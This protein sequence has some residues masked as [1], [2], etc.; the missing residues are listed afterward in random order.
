VEEMGE[1]PVVETG[2]QD[3][4]S[5]PSKVQLVSHYLP[6]ARQAAHDFATRLPGFVDRNALLAAAEDG[7]LDAAQK[8]DT[9]RGDFW[10]YASRRIYGC[11]KD[12]LRREDFMNQGQRRRSRDIATAD[13]ELRASG[14]HDPSDAQIAE[15]LKLPEQAVAESRRLSHASPLSLDADFSLGNGDN[16]HLH[17]ILQMDD[18]PVDEQYDAAEWFHLL[19][20]MISGGFLSHNELFVLYHCYFEGLILKSIGSMM[21]LTE[22][23]AS[24][25]LAAAITKF[26]RRLSSVYDGTMLTINPLKKRRE[27]HGG[28]LESEFR[29]LVA[30]HEDILLPQFPGLFGEEIGSIARDYFFSGLSEEQILEKYRISTARFR[31]ALK[32]ARFRIFQVLDT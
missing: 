2:S 11:M 23:R 22:A 28:W 5:G 27:F 20:D 29:E 16:V 19:S 7:L 8:Y 4:A 14:V 10:P 32:I 13:R 3:R 15:S 31:I 6:W 24:Q 26:R 21:N 18:I 30:T 9:A 1:D 12:F 25:L 17:E